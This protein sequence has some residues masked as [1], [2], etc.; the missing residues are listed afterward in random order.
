M[1][2]PKLTRFNLSVV[3][4]LMAIWLP[5]SPAAQLFESL[6]NLAQSRIKGR[7][8][9]CADDFWEFAKWCKT[10]DA[11]RGAEVFFPTDLT[12][13]GYLDRAFRSV[14]DNEVVMIVKHRQL[15]ITWLLGVIYPNWKMY[16]AAYYDRVWNGAC[17]SQAMKPYGYR[18]LERFK[19]VYHRLPWWLKSAHSG[20]QKNVQRFQFQDTISYEVFAAT[21]DAGRS[22]TLSYFLFDEAQAPKRAAETWAGVS[23][24][25]GAGTHCAIVGTRKAGTWFH[26]QYKKTKSGEVEWPV[27]ELRYSDNPEKR[28]D[29]WEKELKKSG[30]KKRFMREQGDNWEVYEGT[31]VFDDFNPAIH[32]QEFEIFVDANDVV[33]IGVDWGFRHPASIWLYEN[34][35]NQVCQAREYVPEN[36]D[37][38]KFLDRVIDFSLAMFPQCRSFLMYPDPAGLRPNQ[39]SREAK[40]PGE[41]EQQ[42]NVQIAEAK[43]KERNFPCRIICSPWTNTEK[44]IQMRIQATM[45]VLK[46]RP[47]QQPGYLMKRDA[48]TTTKSMFTG[49]YYWDDEDL[50]KALPVKDGIHDHVADALGYALVHMFNLVPRDDKKEPVVV[51]TTVGEIP[52]TNRAYME[53]SGRYSGRVA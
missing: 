20:F 9:L 33:R 44:G 16:Q 45:N 5:D 50:T 39:K 19:F 3:L 49:G 48:C 28:G 18:T 38:E 51:A 2:R 8:Q 1:I 37:V 31:P 6:P 52:E 32:E 27:V 26:L 34:Q 53:D 46:L 4:L 40:L 41:I 17:A 15:L 24:T 11:R 21:E 14:E 13:W 42:T 29:W 36:I 12:E 10:D 30:D 22:T 25:M 23:Q 47:N 43:F 35:E 7:Q